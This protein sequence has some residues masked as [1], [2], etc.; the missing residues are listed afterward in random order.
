MTLCCI[1]FASFP[2]SIQQSVKNGI[3]RIKNFA[4]LARHGALKVQNITMANEDVGQIMNSLRN[5]QEGCLIPPIHEIHVHP[6]VPE[7][8]I[9]DR[10][11]HMGAEFAETDAISWSWHWLAIPALS[12]QGCLFKC[13]VAKLSDQST[14]LTK[15]VTVNVKASPTQ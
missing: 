1:T 15:N 2:R 10:V 6:K 12:S 11:E 7:Q 14:R 13:A 5:T 4:K 9:W 3:K 8:G